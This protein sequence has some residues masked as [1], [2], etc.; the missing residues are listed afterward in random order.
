MP[1]A[2]TTV[3]TASRRRS[4]RPVLIVAVVVTA[5]LLALPYASYRRCI[6]QAY[7]RVSTGSR[8]AQSPCGPIEYAVAGEGPP[9]LVVHGAGGGFDQG[10]EI[11][12]RLSRSGLR[13]IA[14]SR[15]GYL[16]TPLPADA[17]A[18]AQADAHACLLD[19]LHIER[20][21]ILGVSA[22]G[23]SALQ[24][25]LRHPDRTAALVLLVPAAYA[26]RPD[27][28]PPT[29][30]PR[31]T[32]FL[33]D[34]A[35]RSDFLFWAASKVARPTFIRAI[36]G[37]PPGVVASASADEQA[38]V[39]LILEHI[40]PV[41]PRRLGLL[42]DAAVTSSLPR[43]ELERVTAPTL[44]ISGA[45][46]LY[47]TFDGALYTAE[48]VPHARFIGYPSGG[49]MLVDRNAGATS[50]VIAFLKASARS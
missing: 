20:A 32:A 33:F 44:V 23:P 24:F 27:H 46:D 22:G 39:Q 17:S 41:R 50:E 45:D 11:G 30:M 2:Q 3:V 21:A 6:D 15:F 31:G 28:A 18:T 37:T 14:T 26:P 10:L 29:R 19:A 38:R 13:V 49:H 4:R 9:L 47:G 35:L 48:H 36:L 1:D 42:N 25:A 7:A 43:Y 40:L 16:R 34:T 8:I 5:G 12:A